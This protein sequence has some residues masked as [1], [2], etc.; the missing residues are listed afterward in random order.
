MAGAVYTLPMS[1]TTA[2]IGLDDFLRIPDID[3]RRLE[4]IDGEVQE[5]PGR[6]WGHG[7]VAGR[8]FTLLDP[9]GYPSVEPRA[10][11]PRSPAFDS[12]SPIPDVAF[13]RDS[14]PEAT[15]WMTTPPDVAI[16]ILSPGQSRAEMRTKVALYVAFGV[17]CVLV[18]DPERE[19]V[20]MYEGGERTTLTGDD[21]LTLGP[22]PGFRVA[23]RELFAR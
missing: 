9:Y 12:S 20:D 1:A 18:V 23:V 13:Y 6:I 22:V 4:L 15:A 11:I 21:E 19:S 2:R 10:T 7:R 3:E 14:P 5:K 8:M 17:P 16:E